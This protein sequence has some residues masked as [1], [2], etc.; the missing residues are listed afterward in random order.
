MDF[1]E[2]TAELP[3][4]RGAEGLQGDGGDLRSSGVGGRR[5]GASGDREG[6]LLGGLKE[7]ERLYPAQEEIPT[8][9]PEHK[10]SHLRDLS[11]T[12]DSHIQ[13]E[14]EI[15]D[16]ESRAA[17]TEFPSDVDDLGD[18]ML[19]DLSPETVD[20]TSL[21]VRKVFGEKFTSQYCVL[22]LTNDDPKTFIRLV[23][24]LLKPSAAAQNQGSRF[25]PRRWSIIVK[26]V[27][28][29][30]T[31]HEFHR[32]NW[33]DSYNHKIIPT[34][35]SKSRYY[36]R[37]S[38]EESH[39]RQE[40]EYN[41]ITMLR[42]APGL[43][44]RRFNSIFWFPDPPIGE[45]GEL[46]WYRVR[47]KNFMDVQFPFL[48]PRARETHKFLLTPPSSFNSVGKI[49]DLSQKQ[50]VLDRDL[51][52][53]INNALQQREGPPIRIILSLVKGDAPI[54]PTLHKM[55][56]GREIERQE[57]SPADLPIRSTAS[58]S[59]SGQTEPLVLED[60]GEDLRRLERTGLYVG[61][62][63]LSTLYPRAPTASEYYATVRDLRLAENEIMGLEFSCRVCKEP[64]DN[65]DSQVREFADDLLRI[66]T[67]HQ[68][69]KEHYQQHS[70]SNER[71]P[72]CNEPWPSTARKEKIDHMDDHYP[73]YS[74][75][76]IK[77]DPQATDRQQAVEGHNSGYRMGLGTERGEKRSRGDTKEDSTEEQ[78]LAMK[79]Q[80]LDG[81]EDRIPLQLHCP[82]CFTN[83]EVLNDG[84]R[85]VHKASQR[86][87][88]TSTAGME[89]R[90]SYIENKKKHL[91]ALGTSTTVGE[92]KADPAGAMAMTEISGSRKEDPNNSYTLHCSRCFREFKSASQQERDTHYGECDVTGGMAQPWIYIPPNVGRRKRA[93]ILE[94]TNENGNSRA[95]CSRPTGLQQTCPVCFTDVSKITHEQKEEHKKRWGNVYHNWLYLQPEEAEA[96]QNH[97]SLPKGTRKRPTRRYCDKCYTNINSL[98]K[99][100]G[101]KHLRNCKAHVVKLDKRTG[102]DRRV[103]HLDKVLEQMDPDDV[104]GST[105]EEGAWAY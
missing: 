55:L 35:R 36:I 18:D 14:F 27:K 47:S 84:V 39:S 75:D 20:R 62:R 26:D 59:V 40:N 50:H 83:I 44:G 19:S 71:C 10:Q 57:A 91:E 28:G 78:R 92:G 38:P 93:T 63:G 24:R 76:T 23:T 1:D 97:H 46:E 102:A 105:S 6:P 45:E 42:P 54:E 88:P 96:K 5:V 11:Q 3:P 101:E 98:G 72:K 90:R 15:G 52:S 85:A 89:M 77:S 4:E 16:L 81:M 53:E 80:K 9:P 17:D 37:L 69:S 49:F 67:G 100:K 79:R 51:Q 34:F 61:G 12:H 65:Q 104:Y 103:H 66:L 13:S 29:Q 7:S 8:Q 21:A 30:L 2:Y 25:R 94:R 87:K 86:T 68:A 32:Q 22:W 99:T 74:K 43:P 70:P 95:T 82:K 56:T 48:F 60:A 33:R 31:E 58:F 64:L 41:R 73:N